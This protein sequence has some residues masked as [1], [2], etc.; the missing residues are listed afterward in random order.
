M[1]KLENSIEFAAFTDGDQSGVK[2][3]ICIT[4]WSRVCRSLRE[5]IAIFE[6]NFEN[7]NFATVDIEQCQDRCPLH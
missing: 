3:I 5:T 6:N 4:E 7:V 1:V 2:V